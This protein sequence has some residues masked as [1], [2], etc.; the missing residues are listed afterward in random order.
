M[1]KTF[2]LP[3]TLQ[4]TSS[5]MHDPEFRRLMVRLDGLVTELREL[6]EPDFI[7]IVITAAFQ[8][9]PNVPTLLLQL[10]EAANARGHDI[11]IRQRPVSPE[12]L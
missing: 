11:E 10:G 8:R 12:L 2:P 5:R 1:S 6:S 9:S 4:A 3:S 7:D